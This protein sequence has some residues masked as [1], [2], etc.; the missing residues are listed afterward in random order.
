MSNEE[1]RV[2][3]SWDDAPF[4]VNRS[5]PIEKGDKFDCWVPSNF[6]SDLPFVIDSW[7]EPLENDFEFQ[8][9]YGTIFFTIFTILIILLLFFCTLLHYKL[10]KNLQLKKLQ[11]QNKLLNDLIN[12]K[13]KKEEN[14]EIIKKKKLMSKE[15]EEM[16]II[17][18]ISNES[19][20]D[21]YRFL[22]SS[23]LFVGA[24]IS[25]SVNLF[26]H[27]FSRRSLFHFVRFL[28]FI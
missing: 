1:F 9:I 20:G 12:K 15:D 21:S 2:T 10:D 22:L 7:L 3:G 26:A 17:T 4:Y 8:L 28:F 13:I 6:T 25:Y 16:E 23:I 27:F 19:I 11:S 18:E 5:V 14:E 24:I